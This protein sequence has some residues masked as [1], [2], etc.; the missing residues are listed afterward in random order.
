M[1]SGEDRLVREL[2]LGIGGGGEVVV[3]LS[4]EVGLVVGVVIVHPAT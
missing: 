2:R 4:D 1:I 3:E